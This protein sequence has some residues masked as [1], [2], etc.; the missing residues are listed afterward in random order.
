MARDFK[1]AQSWCVGDAMS[2]DFG[3]PWARMKNGPRRKETRAAK[4]FRENAISFDFFNIRF[5][6]DWVDF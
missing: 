1:V 3:G 6:G 5:W 4:D 2:V